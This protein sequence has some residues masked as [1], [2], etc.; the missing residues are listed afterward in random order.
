MFEL[1][2]DTRIASVKRREKITAGSVGIQCGFTFS[3]DWDGLSKTAVFE[4]D[5][6]KIA[7]VLTASAVTIPWEV[8]EEANLDVIV[9]VYGTNGEGTIVI[10]TIYAK[11]GTVAVGTTTGDADNAQTPTATDVQQILA[12]SA[13]AVSTANTANNTADEAKSIAQSVEQRANAGEFNG[14]DGV[15][16]EKGEK[17]D[18]GKDG[19][20]GDK[21]DPGADGA[22][23]TVASV[24]ESTESGGTSVVTFSDGKKLNIKNGLDGQGGSTGTFRELIYPDITEVIKVADYPHHDST[25]IGDNI[26]AFDKPSDGGAVKLYDSNFTLLKS[27]VHNL[28]YTLKDGTERELEM[29]SVDFNSSNRALLVGN[30]ASNYS[31]NDSYLYIFYAAESWLNSVETIT[32][33]NCGDYTQIDVTELGFKAYAWWGA[34]NT[35]NAEIFVSVNYFKDV[36]LLRLGKV[37]DRYD[38]TYTVLRH[39]TQTVKQTNNY[40]QHGGQ[41]YNGSLYLV[42]N[43]SAKNE[44]YRCVLNDDGGLQFDVLDLSQYMASGAL[45]YRYIDGLCIKDGYMYGAPLYINNAYN[46]GSNKVV[47]KIAVPGAGTSAGGVE[48]VRV[49]YGVTPFLAT[50]NAVESGKRVL[51]NALIDGYNVTLA[52]A[53]IT[54]GRGS[55]T[56]T[57]ARRNTLFTVTTNS[58]GTWTNNSDT[59]QVTKNRVTE[60]TAES[61]DTQYPSAKAVWEL[62]NS[63]PNAEGVGF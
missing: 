24:S 34:A 2:I 61:T 44:I 42:N 11:L 30:G 55:I 59:T 32:F 56:F 35:D 37:S 14:K 29:K 16:G 4:T 51:C 19:E 26:V 41:F 17:G 3:S 36:Y 47:L 21:G 8:C 5:K 7:I 13:N 54:T 63:I 10:P 46:T 38:G 53:T 58:D 48:T 52:N 45:R 57:A 40:G 18:P 31:A 6:H 60:I 27:A 12:A 50:R 49:E 25:F 20:K 15:D 1:N 9:G 43:N 33:D 23:V 22:S 39:W 62:F 28:Q